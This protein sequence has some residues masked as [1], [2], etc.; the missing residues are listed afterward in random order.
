[1]KRTLIFS[2]LV[3]LMASVSV[4]SVSAEQDPP[5]PPDPPAR[6]PTPEPPQPVPRCSGEI[7]Q[8][9]IVNDT[10]WDIR[11]KG[12]VEGQEGWQYDTLSPGENSISDSDICDVDYFTIYGA[13]FRTYPSAFPIYQ[14]APRQWSGYMWD[15]QR[16][17]DKSAQVGYPYASCSK[18]NF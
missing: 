16:C 9:I 6:T 7:G 10:P 13:Y 12:D 14:Y 15:K 11:I 17:I 5:L 3:I 1:M 8:G 2:L 4:A 18:H